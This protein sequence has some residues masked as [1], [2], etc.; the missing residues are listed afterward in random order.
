[1]KKLFNKQT[2]NLLLSILGCFLTA[3]SIDC[4]LKPNG[5]TTSGMTGVSI[6][7]ERLTG[8]NYS[9]INMGFTIIILLLTLI[10]LGR[11]E[12][13]KI[14]FISLIYSVMLMLFQQ[15]DFEIKT[16]DRFL[17]MI[18]NAVTYGVGVGLV[19]RCGFTF[20]GTDTVAKI[21]RKTILKFS[22]ISSILM[23]IDAIVVIASGFVFGLETAM[24]S[25]LNHIIAIKVIEY[26]IYKIG[27]QLYHMHIIS[28][29]SDIIGRYIMSEF[30]RGV[31]LHKVVG[32]YTMEEKTQVVTV[33]SPK[34]M[35]MIRNMVASIDKAAF[36]EVIPVLSVHAEGRRFNSLRSDLNDN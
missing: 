30:G 24:Y 3:F 9:Y 2:R 8:I 31:T 5:L 16:S 33:C 17:A 32:G 19:L 10:T 11:K 14:I 25:L 26:M 6:I 1:M 34:E 18:Y 20:G 23:I 13:L 15:I 28:S 29:S 12:V 4:I 7:C 22:S 21:L 35:L 27:T 36:I